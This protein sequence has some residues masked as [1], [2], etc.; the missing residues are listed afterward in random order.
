V[1]R[2]PHPADDMPVDAVL[3]DAGGVLILPHHE[4]MRARLAAFGRTATD[5]ELTR[6]HYLGMAALDAHP[7][8]DWSAYREAVA[9]ACGVPAEHLSATQAA[10]AANPCEWTSPA[11]G[12]VEAL[13]GLAELDVAIAVV[14]NA[15]GRVAQQLA[16]A[17]VCQVGDG[18]GVPVVAIVDSYVVGVEKPDP[19]IFRLGLDACGVPAER[20]I[21]VGDYAHADVRGAEDAGIRAFHLDPHGDCRTA[22]RG[23]HVDGLRA[24]ADV[25]RAGMG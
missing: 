11:A 10:W 20:A 5:A 17:G 7:E 16:E 19:R 4:T 6:A 18:P 12:V 21:M 3:L 25:V 9:S 2:S 1:T 23:A 13:R 8:Q 15:A 22:H 24:V 14:S